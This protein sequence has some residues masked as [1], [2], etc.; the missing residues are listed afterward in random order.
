MGI[1]PNSG[2]MITGGSVG[3]LGKSSNSSPARAGRAEIDNSRGAHGF[4][5][6]SESALALE[7]GMEVEDAFLTA[8]EVVALLIR[9]EPLDDAGA[10]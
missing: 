3:R 5:A 4:R 7:C 8:L 6:G 10:R 9:H 2:K 1:S